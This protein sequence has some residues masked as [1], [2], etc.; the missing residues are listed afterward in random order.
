[1]NK[2]AQTG[3]NNSSNNNYN[4]TMVMSHVADESVDP[5]T[6]THNRFLLMTQVLKHNE[7]IACVELAPDV[8]IFCACLKKE[9]DVTCVELTLDL[10]MNSGV[11]C[12][13]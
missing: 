9:E 5:Q 12:S 10:Q 11:E 4:R 3:S 7:A 13:L 2:L 8:N 1:M 6:D